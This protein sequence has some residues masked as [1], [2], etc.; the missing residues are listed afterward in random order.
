MYKSIMLLGLLWS[1]F[2]FAAYE[3]P[4][5]FLNDKSETKVL[6]FLSEKCPCSVSHINHLNAL[7][8]EYKDVSFYG[9]ISEPAQ[10]KEQEKV[11]LSYFTEENFKL[12]LI[13]DVNQTLVTKYK[14]LKTPHVTLISKGKI[15]YQGG[16]TSNKSFKDSGKKYLSEN[17]KRLKNGESV[18]YAN[19]SSLGC[20][21][22]RRK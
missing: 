22:R 14:A 15:L 16:L 8:S 17:L 3:A 4:D 2:S 13:E 18:K 9:V 20:Y 11:L 10:N 12:P 19:G 21:I 7:V 6:V 1:S 5:K